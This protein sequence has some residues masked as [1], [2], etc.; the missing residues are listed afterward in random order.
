MAAIST[1]QIYEQISSLP[2]EYLEYFILKLMK[3]EKISFSD[4]AVLHTQYVEG[5]K[6]GETEKLM[7]LRSK[8]IDLWCGKKKEMPSNLVALIQEGK[9]NGWVNIT[10]E[11]IDH[12]KWNR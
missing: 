7:M 10:Q 4:I 1:E 6:K 11:Q 5:L 8:V 12:S 3:D 2:K 9:D